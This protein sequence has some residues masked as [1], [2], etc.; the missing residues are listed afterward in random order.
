[1]D[2]P[3]R[4]RLFLA[5]FYLWWGQ[6]YS[7]L[8]SYLWPLFIDCPHC[9]LFVRWGFILIDCSILCIVEWNLLSS[10][11]GSFTAVVRRGCDLFWYFLVIF[12]RVCLRAPYTKGFLSNPL[13]CFMCLCILCSSMSM[14]CCALALRVFSSSDAWLYSIAWHS[15]GSIGQLFV[16]RREESVWSLFLTGIG[17]LCIIVSSMP[18]F[19]N[20]ISKAL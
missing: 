14:I 15:A 8:S 4:N 12:P 9:F 2:T 11:V 1:M 17:D 10:R 6:G 19:T 16:V 20:D 13:I 7:G 5:V 18:H 3:D